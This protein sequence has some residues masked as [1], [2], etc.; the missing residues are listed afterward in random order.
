MDQELFFTQLHCIVSLLKLLTKENEGHEPADL[1]TIEEFTQILTTYLD[2]KATT[3][4]IEKLVTAAQAELD[5]AEVTDIEYT[6]L[7]FEVNHVV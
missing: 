5:D 3:A 2:D 1:F 7:F 4:D 6:K